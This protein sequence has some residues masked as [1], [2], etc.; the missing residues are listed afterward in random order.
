MN[1]AP[2]NAWSGSHIDIP[3]ISAGV[4][5]P[6]GAPTLTS[7]YG[8]QPADDN[9]RVTPGGGRLLANLDRQK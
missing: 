3:G 9:N 1:R 2:T 7:L 6:A 4:S 5:A 8:H